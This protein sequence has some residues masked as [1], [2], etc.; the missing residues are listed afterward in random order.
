MLGEKDIGQALIPVLD[1][2]HEDGML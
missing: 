1:K 2:L